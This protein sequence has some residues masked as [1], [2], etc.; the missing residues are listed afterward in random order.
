MT[1][2]KT[3]QNCRWCSESKALN[4][5]GFTNGAINTH[6]K[7]CVNERARQW[8]EKNPE[9]A[10]QSVA[11]WAKKHPTKARNHRRKTHLRMHYGISVE[12]YAEVV[13]RQGGVC[14]ICKM[15]PTGSRENGKVLHV[16]HDHS[17]GK[18]RGL[19]CSHCNRGLGHFRDSSDLLLKAAA[20]LAAEGS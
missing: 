19:L 6:C 13:A 16:D 5:F 20:Y 11:R 14:R 7:A 10:R 4:A 1:T 2:T 8:R 12:Q 3:A 18:I 9:A 15:T 17:T